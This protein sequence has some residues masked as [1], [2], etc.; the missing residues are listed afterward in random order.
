M[1]TIDSL[2]GIQSIEEALAA[3]GVTATSLTS[4]EQRALNTQGYVVLE[5]VVSKDRVS[6]LR[7][8]F[9]VA[10]AQQLPAGSSQKET[11][12]R[13]IKELQHTEAFLRVCVDPRILAA[14]FH[15]LR[16]RFVCA[17]PHGREPLQGFGQQG[18]HIDWNTAAKGNLYFTASAVC[19]LDEFTK[20]NGAT[21]VVPGSHRNSELP[22]RKTA[23][24]AFV[25]PGQVIVTASAGSVLFFNGHLLHSGTRNRSALR[26]RTLQLSF[27][28]HDT[29][30]FMAQEAQ[31]LTDAVQ[32][33]PVTHPAV[34][35]IFG[36][37]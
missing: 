22:G 13:H 31:T 9:D 24:P 23:D 12:T 29:L 25:H 21:R 36:A 37:D 18:L 16:R 28:A 30:S 19:L 11:G 7:D 3:L 17:F 20:E 4:E 6:Q 33:L 35:F 1:E 32:K 26:R 10:L 8:L 27:M 14:A 15:V 5:S 34:R 2:S